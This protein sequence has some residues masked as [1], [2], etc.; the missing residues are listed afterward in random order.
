MALSGSEGLLS[1]PPRPSCCLIGALAVDSSRQTKCFSPQGT[2]HVANCE[3]AAKNGPRLGARVNFW[4]LLHP[5]TLQPHRNEPG[6]CHLS[7][8]SLLRRVN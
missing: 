5:L 1:R 8:R 3:K 2:K 4:W 6:N 7:T